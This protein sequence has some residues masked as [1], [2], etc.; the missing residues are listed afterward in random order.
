MQKQEK[1]QV[2]VGSTINLEETPLKKNIAVAS[3][4]T[5]DQTWVYLAAGAMAGIG[6]HCCMYPV[7]SI[8]TRM[9]SLRPH[10]SAAYNNIPDAFKKIVKTEGAR[11]FVR[12]IN[13]VAFGAVPAHAS[14]FTSYESS[15]KFL[16][17]IT[18]HEDSSVLLAGAVATLCHDAIM[19]PVEVIKQRCQMYGSPYKGVVQC[20]RNIFK[21]EGL[22]AFYRS[23]TTSYTMNVPFQ[24]IHFWT[25]ETLKKKLNPNGLY[26][27]KAHLMAGALAG[28][29]AAFSTSPFDVA[30]TLLN[31]QE[32]CVLMQC[33]AEKNRINGMI[34]AFRTIYN[35]H[36]L[37]GF[38][39]GVRARVYFQM[40]A[41]GISW[42]VYE[43]FKDYLSLKIT[44]EEMMELT[45]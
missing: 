1:L 20:A 38:F 12:G 4:S 21:T 11:G 45:L 30:R 10:P 41:T 28:G 40:P 6:E 35:M 17:K 29:V 25:Y 44:E 27:C 22:F 42:L 15:K 2:P 5:I 39:R 8:K 9:Q 14:Y 43:F 33:A 26:N 36:G 3:M 19:N 32:K 13:I 18:G 16:T 7:D 37:Y 23:F 34:Y 31:T 24:C